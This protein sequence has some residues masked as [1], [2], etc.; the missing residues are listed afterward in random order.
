MRGVFAYARKGNALAAPGVGGGQAVRVNLLLFTFVAGAASITIAPSLPSPLAAAATAPVALV[1]VWRSRALW[2]A[3]LWCGV[4][5]ATAVGSATL[6]ARL[7]SALAGADLQITGTVSSLVQQSGPVQRFRFDL[8]EDCADCWAPVTIML[9]VYGDALAP[10]EGERWTFTVRLERPRGSVNP[11]L[12]DYDGWL[13]AEGIAARGYVR[14]EPPPHRLD[15]GSTGQVARFRARLRASIEA[16]VDDREIAGL[17]V[18]LTIG[19]SAAI[20]ADNWRVLSFTGTNHL[21]IISGLHVGLI[22][23]ATL[24]LMQRL[25]TRPLAGITS[26]LAATG[27]GLVA[28]MGLPVQRALV[29]A[30]VALAAVVLERRVPPLS[31][32]LIALA[33]VVM[34]NP[35][36]MLSAGFWLSFGAVFTLLFAFGYVTLDVSRRW[37]AWCRD[38]AVSQW[39]VFVGTLPLLLHHVMQVSLVAMLAN[40]I[41]IPWVGCLV[42]PPL[43]VGLALVLVDPGLAAPAFS[44]AAWTMAPLWQ[45]LDWLAGL[46]AVWFAGTTDFFALTL[47]ALGS[48]ILIAPGRPLPRWPALVLWLPLLAGDDPRPESGAIDVHV[49]DVG[50]G[51]AAIVQTSDMTLLYDAGPR[52]GD[53]F[54]AGEQVVTPAIRRLGHARQLDA[55]VVSHPDNDHAGGAGAIL[56]NFVVARAFASEP[57]RPG[58]RLCRQARH[59]RQGQ[60]VVSVAPVALAGS[61]NDRSCV[62][63]VRTPGFA[64]L[65]P[66]DIE[67]AGERRLTSKPMPSID[68]MIVPHHGSRTSSSPAFINHV[69]PDIAIVSA[70]YRSRF[71][72]PDETVVA[73]YEAR[74]I[75]IANTAT[76]GAVT[77]RLRSGQAPEVT[78][79]RERYRRF[80]YD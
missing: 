32:F 67:R 45:M 79:A 53:R 4:F 9:S 34:L 13:L 69:S 21:L 1:A 72:H 5:H 26:L 74:G 73:R 76:D 46:R 29:M 14:S 15:T 59:W 75:R 36:A 54:D 33:L 49:V 80:W 3:G 52:F 31:L 41:A 39:I 12:F 77:V 43:L 35:F 40:V 23:G 78:L 25:T 61:D 18:A 66:G 64:V 10:R 47:A 48:L 2:L 65:L 71:G 56:D 68:V 27:Y 6:A 24:R 44:F 22:A 50:Q 19:D 62:V 30:A 16:A 17:L 51:L 42:I 28:G 63:L 57:I 37:Q 20:G 7:P 8:D 70:G 11:G 38:A 55:F 60:T 58:V